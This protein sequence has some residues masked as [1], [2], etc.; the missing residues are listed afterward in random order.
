[1]KNEIKAVC[2]M[3]LVIAAVLCAGRAGAEMAISMEPVG[4]AAK[5]A[6]WGQASRPSSADRL[7]EAA[8]RLAEA[9]SA[10]DN[11]KAEALLAGI[12][13]GAERK[14]EA[15]PVYVESKPAA[16]APAVP[17][18][19]KRVSIAKAAVADLEEAA[20]DSVTEDEN[21]GKEEEAVAKADEAEA[22]DSGASEEE[23]K[24]APT[25]FDTL[26]GGGLGML[27]VILLLLL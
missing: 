13:S 25:L 16:A 2:G 27:L 8:E 17:A 15:A 11:A 1:M 6:V 9:S 14:E 22:G 4:Y 20:G 7:S 21:T 26:F 12:F 3:T 5:P 23:A 19:V 24:P 10:G 18:P